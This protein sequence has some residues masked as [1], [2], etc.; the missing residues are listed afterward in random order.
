MP[1]ESE[2]VSRADRLLALRA[3]PGFDTLGAPELWRVAAT[4]RPRAFDAGEQIVP[5][6]L[7]LSSLELLV[8]GSVEIV[9]SSGDRRTLR[10]P[11]VLG[12]LAELLDDVK[13][14]N[15]VA[16]ER[17]LTLGFERADLED[18][19]EDDFGVFLGL[20]RGLARRVARKAA[21]SSGAVP[22][23]RSATG[24]SHDPALDLVDLI[25]LLKRQ[26]YLARAEIAALAAL[27][28]QAE[29][30]AFPSGS[31]LISTG[32]VPER[33]LLITAGSVVVEPRRRSVALG[34]GDQLGM[35]EALAAVPVSF[36]AIA[37]GPVST[38]CCSASSLVD[39]VE[40][41]PSLGLG[42]LHALAHDARGQ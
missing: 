33:F 1:S 36:T 8:K 12:T 3:C 15:V 20:L 14:P 2:Q 34:P 22:A 17:T 10:P 19:L 23:R 42:L 9:D 32:T 4:L 7:P 16:R 6:G 31:P 27:G 24:S 35:L 18:L 30:V 37:D 39:L 21:D 29:R 11:D 5:S 38:L 40:D 25:L 28:Q 41:Y 26:P 13:A